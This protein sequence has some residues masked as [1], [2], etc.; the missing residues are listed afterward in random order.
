MDEAETTRTDRF[1][2]TTLRLWA[3]ATATFVA[4]NGAL[5]A[6]HGPAVFDSLVQAGPVSGLKLTYGALALVWLASGLA[7]ALLRRPGWRARHGL[8]TVCCFLAL[9]LYA[10]VLRE[11]LEYPDTGDYM[12]AAFDLAEGRPLHERYIYPPLLAALLEPLVPLGRGALRTALW[13]ANLLAVPAFT[14]LLALALVRYGFERRLAA[15]VGLAFVVFNVPV[16]RTLVYGQVNLHVANLVLLALLA[17]PRR[18]AGSSLALALAVHL[19]TSPVVLAL[20]FLSERRWRWLAA[21]LGWLA[22]IAAVLYAVH[23]AQP[24]LDFLRNAP[25]VYAWAEPSFREN[26]IDNFLRSTA[27]LV[28][29]PLGVLGRPPVRLVVKAALLAVAL[30]AAARAVRRSTFVPGDA[31]VGHVL[32]GWPALAVLMVL[33]SPLVWEHHPVF[34]ALPFLAITRKLETTGEWSAWSLAYLVVYL[35][36]TF[37]FYPWSFGRLAGLVLLLA[38]LYRVADGRPD[39]AAFRRAHERLG[40]APGVP[41]A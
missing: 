31:V 5:A 2:T 13:V 16:L 25:G 38:L 7:L 36:P 10:N 17:H 39:G 20:P 8:L 40:L 11:R 37:D 14:A 33:A 41:A 18:P 28:G 29:G 24:F 9:A 19:K 15:L 6:L 32:N 26:S 34:T 30:A 1:L 35:L 4:A 22:A 3:A 27:A 23:G 12:R 21:F